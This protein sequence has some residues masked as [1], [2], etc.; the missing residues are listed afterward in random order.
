MRA[1]WKGIVQFGPVHVPVKLYTAVEDIRSH[2]HLLHDNDLEPLEQKMVCTEEDAAVERED[3]VKGYPLDERRYVMVEPQELEAFNP[4][5]SRVIDAMEFVSV[6]ELDPRYQNRTYYLGPDDN[7]QAYADLAESLRQ[8]R[9]AGVCRWV[10]RKKTY[11]GLLQCGRSAIS[12][13]TCRYTDEIIDED[14]LS[15]PQAKLGEKEQK[16]AAQLISA[17]M[18]DFKPDQYTDEYQSRLRDL[19]RQKARGEEVKLTKP[20]KIHKTKE[21]ELLD[22]LESSLATLTRPRQTKKTKK[23]HRKK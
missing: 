23:T 2:S 9:L 19:I 1:I 22:K 12:L 7:E 16:A 11:L 8:S 17:M 6:D 5:P 21:D 10:M 13:T 3:I 14:S 20:R 4:E 18:D 15:I